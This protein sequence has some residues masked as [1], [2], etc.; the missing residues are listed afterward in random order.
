MEAQD[1]EQPRGEAQTAMS[2]IECYVLS[3]LSNFAYFF[4]FSSIFGVSVMRDSLPSFQALC[5]MSC[6][7]KCHVCATD[8]D[9]IYEFNSSAELHVENMRIEKTFARTQTRCSRA[10]SLR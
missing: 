1:P 7:G 10:L 4:A 6:I 9:V 8:Y 5:V 2:F 3:F